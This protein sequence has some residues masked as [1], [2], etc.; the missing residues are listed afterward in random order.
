MNKKE[1]NEALA[2][3]NTA[4]KELRDC[5]RVELWERQSNVSNRCD[6]WKK[7]SRTQQ[8]TPIQIY[9]LNKVVGV[10]KKL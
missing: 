9:G 6:R 4:N 5:G 10:Y 2:R 7:G 3:E 1:W 8:T